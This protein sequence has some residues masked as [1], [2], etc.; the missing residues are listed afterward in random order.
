MISRLRE[1]VL[2]AGLG[3]TRRLRVGQFLE[4]TIRPDHRQE[5]ALD[6]GYMRRT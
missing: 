1:T 4:K 2:E 3:T 6:F 5:A